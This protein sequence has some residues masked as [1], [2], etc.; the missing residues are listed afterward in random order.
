MD[1]FVRDKLTEWNFSEYI[2]RFKDEE[3]DKESFLL[4]D[5][6][7][8]ANLI[9]KLG[10]RYKFQEKH[11]AIQKE[12]E[13]DGTATDSQVQT[14]STMAWASLDQA[15]A[16]SISPQ[17]KRK[18]P[19]TF[20]S[21][22][23]PPKQPC[24]S[25]P[26]QPTSKFER[27][28][29]KAAET[30]VTQVLEKLKTLP[31][32]E[33]IDYLK[34]KM[35]KLR[36]GVKNKVLVGVFGKTGAGKSSLINAILGEP[37]CLPNGANISACTSVMIQVEAN[38]TN[39]S[40]EAEIEFISKKASELSGKIACYTR[41][42]NKMEVKHYW[43]LVKCVTI[44]VPNTKE[45][46]EHIVLLD[47]P[48]TGDCN[49]TRDNMWKSHLSQ[50]SSV[51][52]VNDIQRAASEREPWMILESSFSYLIQGGECEN[53][54]F[55]CTK[56]DDINP[57]NYLGSPVLKNT[58]LHLDL[59][60]K[61][62]AERK[63]GCIQHR[64]EQAKI[65]LGERFN[66]EVVKKKP[67]I[68]MEKIFQV[69]TVSAEEF[70]NDENPILEQ[71]QTEIPQLKQ[72]LEDMNERHSKTAVKDY[73]SG[74]YGILS[75]IKAANSNDSTMV[76]MKSN[77]Y[78]LLKDSLEEQLSTITSLMTKHYNDLKK[79]LSEG[80]ANSKKSCLQIAKEKVITPEARKDGRG[81]HRTLSSLC[82]NKGFCRST[83]GD[84][85]DLNKTLAESM[86]AAI[87]EKFALIFPNAGTTGESIYKKICNFSIISDNMAK[88]WEN[89]PMSLYLMFLTT[90]ENF[91]KDKLKRDVLLR[92]KVIYESLTDEVQIIMCPCYEEASKISGKG[93]LKKTQELLVKHIDSS[94][95][96]MF[97]NAQKKML[98]G[99]ENLR[100]YIEQ[101]LRTE[102]LESL[103]RSLKTPNSLSLPDVS[104]QLEN[105]ETYKMLAL[106]ERTSQI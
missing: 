16:P 47:L 60:K 100:E 51:W 98:E 69:F 24:F 15:A 62:A 66:D 53:I 76:E 40:Y 33:F 89:T 36:T 90:E 42:D 88:E 106:R 39:Y 29:M 49:K 46:L 101:T 14:S 58:E 81:Y 35:T 6:K 18:N 13:N 63:R 99:F 10:P 82:R 30:C 52:I 32:K 28:A 64:N 19:P 1:N 105:M 83:N 31:K 102:L 96:P 45:L 34:G 59:E 12:L 43:P 3:I 48:G 70:Q 21:T 61:G 41:S 104:E 103:K 75:L 7:A 72:V 74:V 79:L 2:D 50:C 11:K 20:P 97:D 56:T 67:F 5:E 71:E 78:Q 27:Q 44:K 87:N 77:M 86:Y 25:K 92:K 55:I 94:K 54:T 95:N 85:T 80:V 93:T 17:G 9:P 22:S 8:F 38:M 91:L 4:L 73:I 84:I 57:K 26:T 23:T 37:N 68:Q 65:M